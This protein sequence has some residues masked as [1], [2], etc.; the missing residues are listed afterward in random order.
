MAKTLWIHVG[1]PKTGSTALQSFCGENRDLLSERGLSYPSMPDVLHSPNPDKNGLFL[2]SGLTGASQPDPTPEQS[3]LMQRCLDVIAREFETHD[4]VLV[5]EEVVWIRMVNDMMFC[6]DVLTAHAREHRYTIK[7]IAYLRRQDIFA[8]SRYKQRTRAG[9]LSQHWES[10]VAHQAATV[11][12]YHAILERFARIVGTGNVV[13]RVYDR[14]LL[15]RDGGSLFTDFLGALGISGI[16]DFKPPERT[17]ERTTSCNFTACMYALN[18]SPFRGERYLGNYFDLA[19]TLTE[20]RRGQVPDMQM[21]SQ[22]EARALMGQFEEGNDAIARDYLHRDGP[23]FDMTFPAAMKWK[24]D[25]SWMA[26]DM[27]LFFQGVNRMQTELISK[28]DAGDGAAYGESAY[29]ES[30][31]GSGSGLDGGLDE[32]ELSLAEAEDDIDGPSRI[33]QDFEAGMLGTREES[34]LGNVIRCLADFFMLRERLIRDGEPVE[35]MS[36]ETVALLASSM[37]PQSDAHARLVGSWN[38]SREAA[39]TA[40]ERNAELRERNGQLQSE[41]AAHKADA[42]ALR[43]QLDAR[44]SARLRRAIGRLVGRS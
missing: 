27:L 24:C 8:E 36:D 37:L 43:R 30:A 25:N 3:A 15:E 19:C 6:W 40:R 39:S 42:D 7:V 9:I 23:L 44:L 10:W 5:S 38:R 34:T 20:Q 32:E 31:G 14:K 33:Q 22:S 28:R 13:V 18:A 2:V 26:D 21:F 1:H 16:G 11:L 41:S 17:K 12:D 29:G 4:S 35:V